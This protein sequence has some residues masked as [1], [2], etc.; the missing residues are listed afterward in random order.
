MLHT[1]ELST[2]PRLRHLVDAGYWGSTTD[3]NWSDVARKSLL[4]DRPER[5]ARGRL[6]GGTLACVSQRDA[7]GS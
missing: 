7:G 1:R 6:A 4:D 5:G 2:G 3:F